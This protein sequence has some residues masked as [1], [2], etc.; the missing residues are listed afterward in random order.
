MPSYSSIFIKGKVIL[1]CAILATIIFSKLNL[2]SVCIIAIVL[3]W[4]FEGN[5]REK[6]SALRSDMLF[7]A[8]LAFTL[9]NIFSIFYSPTLSA[10]WKHAES[11]LGYLII[12]LVLSSS[13]ISS[14]N[15]KDIMLFLTICISAAAVICLTVAGVKFWKTGSPE[16]FFYHNL[17]SPL[18]HHAVYF[19]VFAF[20]S[21]LFLVFEYWESSMPGK[22]KML[23]ISWIVFLLVLIFLLSSKLVLILLFIFLSAM[24]VRRIFKTNKSKY[25]WFLLIVPLLI[26]SL[27]F[28]F[29]NPVKNRFTNLLEGNMHVLQQKTFHPA[30]YFNGFQFRLLLWRI[31][32]MILNDKDAWL[33]GMSPAASQDMLR[34]KYRELNLYTGDVNKTNNGYLD[35]NCHNEFLQTTLQLGLPGLAL[36]LAIFCIMI[37]R[38]AVHHEPVLYGILLIIFCFCFT[39]SVFERQYG[40][41]LFTVFPLLYAKNRMPG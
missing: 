15:R 23:I 6:F 37:S 18:N 31:T 34:E 22:R 11:K 21:V 2:N 41:I 3:L 29:D 19:A 7:L 24:L 12:P 17:V 30:D 27:I 1:I 4:V 14:G 13:K 40:M 8:F 38:A 9:A 10:G 36:I 26:M 39:E 35:Y 32:F 33:T 28:S 20:I 5:F 25:S 16:Y